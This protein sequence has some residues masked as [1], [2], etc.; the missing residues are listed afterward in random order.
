MSEMRN[1]RGVIGAFLFVVVGLGI[2]L[3]WVEGSGLCVPAA[4]DY[5]NRMPYRIVS[6]GVMVLVDLV[7]AV[8]FLANVIQQKISGQRLRAAEKLGQR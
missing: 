8:S 5:F 6:L 1:N 4:V 2:Y 7:F 3:F